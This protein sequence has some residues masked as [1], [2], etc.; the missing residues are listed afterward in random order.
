MQDTHDRKRKRGQ[1]VN[2][3]TEGLHTPPKVCSNIENIT[4]SLTFNVPSKSEPDKKYTVQLVPNNTNGIELI[5]S[6]RDQYG[7]QFKNFYCYHINA[8]VISLFDK[9]VNTMYELSINN[10]TT[11][12]IS[13][14]AQKLAAL[15]SISGE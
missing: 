3:L 10:C 7:P 15:L 12:D 5:C 14:V 2:K 4:G 13:T 1:L 9:S 11:Q 6:C 8:A